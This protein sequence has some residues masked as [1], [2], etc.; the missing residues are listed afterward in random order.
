MGSRKRISD[1]IKSESV[2][3]GDMIIIGYLLIM[4]SAVLQ[5]HTCRDL[6]IVFIDIMLILGVWLVALSIKEDK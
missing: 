2:L 1:G 3:G 5:Q 4:V 6:K